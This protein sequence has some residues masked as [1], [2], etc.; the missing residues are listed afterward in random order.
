MALLVLR[1]VFVLVAAGMSVS[2]FNENPALLNQRDVWRVFGAVIPLAIAVIAI[3]NRMDTR[4]A[5]MITLGVAFLVW[6]VSMIGP[7]LS[8]FTTESVKGHAQGSSDGP[9][10]AIDPRFRYEG[11]ISRDRG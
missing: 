7:P 8:G 4:I 10:V 2:F 3:D 6:I 9:G 1:C 11:G 5:T